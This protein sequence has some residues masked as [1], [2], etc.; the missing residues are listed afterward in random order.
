MQALGEKADV[1]ARIADVTHEKT[2]EVKERAE[3]IRDAV[4]SSM[5]EA[6]QQKVQAAGGAARSS[7]DRIRS[8]PRKRNAVLAGV[9][10]LV[11]VRRLRRRRRRA[12]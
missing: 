1:K 5:P 2:A 6:G 3:G 8:D 11:L 9:T 7:V 4:L 12:H 10:V